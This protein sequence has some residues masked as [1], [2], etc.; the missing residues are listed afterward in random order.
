MVTLVFVDVWWHF[1][2][3]VD[4]ISGDKDVV[5]LLDMSGSM[6][7]IRLDLA[8][9]AAIQL[10]NSLSDQDSFHVLRVDGQVSSLGGCFTSRVRASVD[11]KLAMARIIS[12]TNDSYGVADFSTA[13]NVA[14][15]KLMVSD[16][17]L[18][19]TCLLS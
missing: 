6:L 16:R 8:R 9:L 3:Y 18:L 19:Q 5:L 1:S 2:R 17:V 10:L 7:G 14:H 15:S 4:T 12:R 13:L 11:N